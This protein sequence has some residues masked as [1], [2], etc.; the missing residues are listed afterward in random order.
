[1]YLVTGCAGFIGMHLTLSL[2][3]KNKSVI[4]IDNLNNYYDVNLK[5][6]RLLNLKKF[7]KFNFKKVD[8]KNLNSLKKIVKNYKIDYIINL[9]A[10]AGVRYS[11]TN[12]ET[13]FENNIRGFFNI[14]EIAKNKK[15]K[16]LVYASSSSVYG[17]S[18]KK[19][20]KE[21]DNVDQPISF[22][23]SSKRSN[24]LM[25]HSYSYIYNIP[26][27]GIRYFSVYGPWGR[28]DM[29][30]FIFTK[31][32]LSGENIDVFNKGKMKR[33]F[34]FID[35]AVDATYKIIHKI[36]KIR[37]PNKIC[38]FKIF[39]VGGGN[40]ISLINYIKLIETN[41]GIKAKKNL[42]G[43]QLGDVK[44]TLSNNNNLKSSVKFNPKT[45]IKVGIRKF[46]DWYKR[47][48]LNEK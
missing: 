39:N 40:T 18:Q 27:T 44:A 25:A 9:A 13:Y 20:F 46:I 32:I 5:K 33:D 15:V 4:G 42:K 38:K 48:Y 12:P 47:F 28:P 34:T 1:M 11:I 45:N 31:K 2:L 24:E 3:K 22:Y 23:A 36:P 29:S 19:I 10:Q 7:K 6:K 16:H 30:L 37:R 17:A 8:I 26:V 35:D 41:L 21:S 14:L 43:M